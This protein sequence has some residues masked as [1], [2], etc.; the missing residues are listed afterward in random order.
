MNST[1]TISHQ[2]R[3]V[4]SRGQRNPRD[5]H[6]IAYDQN[7]PFNICAA[8]HTP[9]YEGSSYEE[10][11]YSGAKYLPKYK[12]TVCVVDGLSQVG[13]AGSGLRNTV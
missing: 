1:L 5:A 8:T 4:V 13:L 3:A 10:S 6:E 11:A 12:G 7:T 9:I 2:A